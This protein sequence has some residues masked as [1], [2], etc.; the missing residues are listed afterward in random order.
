M[1]AGSRKLVR[2][3][4]AVSA[5]EAAAVDVEVMRF[6]MSLSAK[7]GGPV[8][9][10]GCIDIYVVALQATN[11]QHAEQLM[12]NEIELVLQSMVLDVERSVIADESDAVTAQQA[13]AAEGGWQ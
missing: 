5:R 12:D 2:Y 6:T 3:E 1:T 10:K 7:M 9:Q 13:Q 4:A 8:L 11:T